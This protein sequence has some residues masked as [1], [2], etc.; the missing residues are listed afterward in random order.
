MTQVL[1]STTDRR[2]PDSTAPP[3]WRPRRRGVRFLVGITLVVAA[4]GI[5][6]A[7]AFAAVARANGSYVDLGARG[8]YRTDR[9]G[10][11]TETTNW[12]TTL[13]GW[14]GSVR[15]E[16][17]AAGDE[18]I[19][20]GVATPDAARRYL[21]DIGYTTIGELDG[22][23]V[24]RTEH[25]G[26]GRAQ[27]PRH[28]VDWTAHAEGTATQTLRWDATDR[29]QMVVAMNADGSRAVHVRIV[30]SAVTVDR[31]PWWLPAGALALGAVMLLIGVVV[32]QWAIR[33]RRAAT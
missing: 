24:V 19:F 8:D 18:P 29:P 32:L 12:R 21:A 3:R 2:T 5:I 22:G 20:V 13:F 4:V 33:G 15:V 31:M 11:A 27:P 25:E 9:Y 6:G 28:A 30:S 7:G 10:L 23:D 26:A 17:A 14:S 16:V 1:E